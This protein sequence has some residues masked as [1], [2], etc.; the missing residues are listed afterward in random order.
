MTHALV[1]TAV[2]I[3][4]A[5]E[6]SA[7]PRTTTHAPAVR[8]RPLRIAAALCSVLLLVSTGLAVASTQAP[9]IAAFAG[10]LIVAGGLLR[11]RAMR[12][13]GSHFRTEAG[14]SALVTTGIHG[15]MRHPSE[16]GLLCWVVG[17]WLAAPGPWAT[18][19]ALAQLP[20]LAM[21]LRIE[22]AA[23]A[24]RFGPAWAAYAAS[25]PRFSLR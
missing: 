7:A 9:W 6:A 22:D 24:A 14:A 3:A 15:R 12:N 4:I 8:G 20:L 23:L 5:L 1:V 19:L 2:C 25:T 21:R 18:A 13:L 16:L 17:L 10:T 11:A